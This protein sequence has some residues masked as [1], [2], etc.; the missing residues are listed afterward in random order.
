MMKK[1][2][3]LFSFCVFGFVVYYTTH[4]QNTPTPVQARN[5]IKVQKKN[6]KATFS[7][8]KQIDMVEHKIIPKESSRAPASKLPMRGGRFIEGAGASKYVSPTEELEFINKVNPKW[9]E[10]LGRKLTRFLPEGTEVI[11]KKEKSLIYINKG[12]GQYRE[13]VLVSY[14][15]AD[16]RT[17]SHRAMVDSSSGK[18]L[19]NFNRQQNEYFRGRPGGFTHPLAQ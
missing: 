14:K 12:K 5:T 1:I 11:V 18:V 7:H 17:S 10:L 16:G 6:G 19:F 3:I 4:N 8:P 2:L 13:Q 9:K 15:L